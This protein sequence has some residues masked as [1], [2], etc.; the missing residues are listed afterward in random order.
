MPSK[1]KQQ[2]KFM[3]IVRSIQKGEAP[4]GKFSKTAQKAAKSMK[5]GSVRKY[6][7]TKHDDLPK[8]VKEERDYKDEYKKFQSSTK[9]KKYRAE[10]NKYNRKKGTYGNGDGKDASHKGGKIVGFE[11]QSKN[12]GRAEKSRLKKEG[13]LNEN[14]AV[15]ATAARMAI[16]NAQG[17]KV[18]VNTARQSKYASKD[19]STHKKA[20]SIFQR[21][22]D[23]F[24]KKKDDK[25]KKKSTPTT[26]ADFRRSRKENVNEAMSESQRFKVYNSLKKGDIVSIKYDSSIQK[27]SKY[28]PYVVT[29]G[30]TK[31][32]K[33]KIERIILKSPKNPRF[34]AYLYNRDGDVS[35]ALGDMA[36]SI[37]DMKK[38]KVKESVDERKYNHKKTGDD[39]LGGFNSSKGD[40]EM[41]ADK[42]GKYY[43][44][45]KPKGKKAK[46]IDLPKRIK[47]R[48]DADNFHDKIKKS[49]GESV[50]ER[51]PAGEQ[52]LVYQFKKLSTSQ[53]DELDAM[54]ARAGINGVPDFNKKTW[55][56]YANRDAM[57]LKKNKTLQKFIKLKGGQQI[58]EG[59]GGELKGSEKK[60]FEND[61]KKNGEQL[62]YTLTGESDVKE[63]L[64]RVVKEEVSNII[65]ERMD[66]RQAGET[67]KQLGGN[68]FIAMTGAKNF[69]VGPKGMGFKIGRNSKSINYVRIDLKSND[70]YDMEFIRLR[71]SQIKVVKRVT[72]VYN[73]QLQKMFTKYTGMYTSL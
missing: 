58:K 23:K 18:S 27:G 9:S 40:T 25:P 10:L 34:K 73:D 66:K 55:S 29:K 69:A 36:A 19:P 26:A 24:T 53:M 46:Y 11:S 38:G 33:G 70:L 67:L 42:K 72:G 37:V 44:W 54:F 71:K 3:G 59:F 21:I 62:G 30:K 32:M 64:R 16:Q 61:R 13:T 14:P 48:S 63:T 20:K 68:K 51:I 15:I 2:Q 12:R 41:F 17:K 49:M 43:L 65:S 60:K 5:K 31:L 6:A 7:K 39:Y 57:K 4:A 22:K 47:N 45:V 8:K 50:N 28:I 52:K 1:S 56:T 35:L